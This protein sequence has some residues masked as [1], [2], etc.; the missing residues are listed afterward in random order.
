MSFESYKTSLTSFPITK[1]FWN[2][3]NGFSY[4]IVKMPLTP[5]VAIFDATIGRLVNVIQTYEKNKKIHQE[6]NNLA[7]RLT[8]LES[9]LKEF[10]N[11]FKD[12]ILKTAIIITTL[13]TVILFDNSILLG[14]GLGALGA[15]IDLLLSFIG[16]FC[17]QKI[18][19]SNRSESKIT[20]SQEFQPKSDA[21]MKVM[22]ELK[23]FEPI[24][25]DI[26]LPVIEEILFRGILQSSVKKIIPL[27]LPSYI[28]ISSKIAILVSSIFFGFAHFSQSKK[29]AVQ[30]GIKSYFIQGPLMER[31]GLLH[32]ISAHITNNNIC[33]ISLIFLI[34][35]MISTIKNDINQINKQ[36]QGKS[37]QKA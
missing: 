36:I 12:Y 6:N 8:I 31:Y 30:A 4:Q 2:Y 25:M 5:V 24:S 19:S 34:Y 27:L 1:E 22:R 23:K 10:K 26:G 9:Q 11:I 32:S 35:R 28:S 17:I 18:K 16:K 21:R 15:S 29:Q 13:A 20:D 14:I 3:S 7:H 37:L 33:S